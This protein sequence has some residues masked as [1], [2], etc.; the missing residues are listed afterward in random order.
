MLTGALNRALYGARDECVST[1]A[2]LQSGDIGDNFPP[3][4]AISSLRHFFH[5]GFA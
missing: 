1:N 3:C 4:A 5:P 2:T